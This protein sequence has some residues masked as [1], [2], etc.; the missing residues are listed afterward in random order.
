MPSLTYNLNIVQ[1]DKGL[2]TIY[3]NTTGVTTEQY[4]LVCIYKHSKG[5]KTLTTTVVLA[6]KQW[7]LQATDDGWYQFKLNEVGI[8]DSRYE[9]DVV[10]LINGYKCLN[11]L[12]LSNGCGCDFD[13]DKW[14]SIYTK[15]LSAKA[16]ACNCLFSVAQC[17]LENLTKNCKGC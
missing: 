2:F 8:N 10:S 16:A 12:L 4:Q 7:T 17:I 15:L 6:N 3:N 9:K 5:D 1:D 13:L 11:S 14:Q